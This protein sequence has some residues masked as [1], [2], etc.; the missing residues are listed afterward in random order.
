MMQTEPFVNL[1]DVAIL[2]RVKNRIL[3]ELSDV[4]VQS[5]DHLIIALH[6]VCIECREP[7]E[8]RK[9]VN[10]IL[11]KLKVLETM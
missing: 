10:Y 11:N 1:L 6:E 7:A 5:K 4:I 9:D 2:H 3:P 8:S